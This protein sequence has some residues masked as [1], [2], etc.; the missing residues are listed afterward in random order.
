MNTNIIIIGGGVSGITTALTLQLMGI[1]TT[2]YADQLVDENVPP[3]PMFASLYP[4]ASVIPH[5]VQSPKL[6]TLF[7][8]SLA[9]FHALYQ[10]NFEN[11]VEHRHFE[12]YEFPVEP[13][14]YTRYLSGFSTID[15]SNITPIPRRPGAPELH[16]WVFD[17]FVAEWPYYMHNLYDCYR[18]AGGILKQKRLEK[19]D[20]RKLPADLILNCAGARSGEL[21]D[22]PEQQE[23]VRGHLVCVPDQEPLTDAQ[24][25][26]VSYNYTPL[27]SVYSTPGGAPSD[28]YLYPVHGKWV[29]GGSRQFGRLND[30]GDWE[31]ETH[32]ESINIGG[33]KVP[34]P[35]LELNRAILDNSY[36]LQLPD[37]LSTM[38][39]R[40]GY[41]FSRTGTSEGLRLEAER[42]CG[43]EI[44]HN[45]GHG[46]AGVTLSWG[47]ALA[48]LKY[49]VQRPEFDYTLNLGNLTA[50]L[51]KHLQLELQKVYLEY[52]HAKI[53]H[54]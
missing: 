35:I 45:Y 28:V 47:C 46:G 5:S 9:L 31:G 52:D 21:F 50:P 19:D 51:L 40:A 43:K 4:A 14:S 18:E 1:K 44:V 53:E 49:I 2:C 20:I 7:P 13:P 48:I 16:G 33:L 29:L 37:D 3:D 30:A 11:L 34:G 6:D 22:D 42:A 8:A 27:T 23:Y 39:A 10:H 36:Q 12:L 41:R 24:D 32:R 54:I 15:E 26:L 38:T 17:C 25:W